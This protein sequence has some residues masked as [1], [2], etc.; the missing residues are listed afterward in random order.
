[1][2][3]ASR[4]VQAV[5][6]DVREGSMAVPVGTQLACSLAAAIG[7][8]LTVACF[9]PGYMSPDSVE[10]L[11]QGRAMSF[12]AWPPPV[13]SLLWGLLV[14]ILPGPARILVFYHNLLSFR[15]V[16]FFSSPP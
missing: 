7:F 11:R 14:R 2:N 1:M 13:M 3:L 15:F 6:S 12:G 5:G 8:V 4:H 16:P 10:Q 9:F